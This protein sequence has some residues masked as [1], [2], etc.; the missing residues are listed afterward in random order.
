MIEG[1]GEDSCGNSGTDETPQERKR[2]G[3][4]AAEQAV[5]IIY[6]D[7]SPLDE[8][9]FVT[10]QP[11]SLLFLKNNVHFLDFHFYLFYIS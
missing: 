2:R 6:P 1:Q 10:S 8:I 5:Q 4:S 3:G 11:L 7:C 9:H